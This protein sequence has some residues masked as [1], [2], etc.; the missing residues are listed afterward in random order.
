MNRTIESV[1]VPQQDD[2]GKV[3]AVIRAIEDGVSRAGLAEAAGL[4]SRHLRYTLHAARTLGLAARRGEAWVVTQPGMDLLARTVGSSE[5]RDWLRTTIATNRVIHEVAPDLFDDDPPS[6]EALAER[7]TERT[8]LSPSTAARRA[9]TLLSWREQA[10]VEPW[11][12]VAGVDL[13]AA[14]EPEPEPGPAPGD[15]MT[16]FQE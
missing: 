4:S 1:D 13:E 6:A 2:L 16:L 7:L 12:V 8:G 9:L 10:A 15:Q 3:R 5:E 14:P 11:A